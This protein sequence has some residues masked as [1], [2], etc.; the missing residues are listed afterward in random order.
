M[1]DAVDIGIYVLA[2][3]NAWAIV[4]AFSTQIRWPFTHEPG[5]EET[6]CRV[7]ATPTV[8]DIV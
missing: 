4:S 1:L 2:A 7:A 5:L 8:Y 3:T 6:S